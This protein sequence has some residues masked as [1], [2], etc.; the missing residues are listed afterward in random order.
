MLPNPST[1]SRR[2]DDPLGF[3]LDRLL[4]R[5][6]RICDRVT[7]KPPMPV[8]LREPVEMPEETLQAS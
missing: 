6:G 1:V 2:A 4:A 7:R 8:E 3:M 5:V